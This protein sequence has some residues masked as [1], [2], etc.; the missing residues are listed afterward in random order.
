M[1]INL[2]NKSV[3]YSCDYCNYS[4]SY[5]K[6][7]KKHTLTK[8][9]I[10]NSNEIYGNEQEMKKILTC[11]NCNKVFK[12]N[13][14]LWKHNKKCNLE[15]NTSIIN[16]NNKDDLI[17]QILKQNAELIKQNNDLIKGQKDMMIK[18]TENS[19]TN[20]NDNLYNKAFNILK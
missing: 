6:D 13:A 12:T 17:I 4:T 7:Y 10:M 3:K 2:S 18:F 15:V 1:E 14:G 16:T 5:S 11:E 19:T 8:K 20:I 9:H